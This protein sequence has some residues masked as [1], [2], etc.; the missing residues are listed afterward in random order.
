MAEQTSQQLSPELIT[1]ALRSALLLI[2]DW[3]PLPKEVEQTLP[4]QYLAMLVRLTE[5]LKRQGLAGPNATR[6]QRML[7]IRKQMQQWGLL[8]QPSQPSADQIINQYPTAARNSVLA[9][10]TL[11]VQQDNAQQTLG[12]Q[13]ALAATRQGATLA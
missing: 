5:S 1:T 13:R 6:P 8:Q 4:P 11:A 7:A 9:N 12:A 3:K 2:A 10:E